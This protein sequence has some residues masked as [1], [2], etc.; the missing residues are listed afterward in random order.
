MQGDSLGTAPWPPWHG[1]AK[2]P[3]SPCAFLCFLSAW[4]AQ[5]VGGCPL[6]GT[7][8]REGRLAAPRS[9]LS[10]QGARGAAAVPRLPCAGGTR[11][12]PCHAPHGL[13]R[14]SWLGDSAQGAAFSQTNVA[15]V[16]EGTGRVRLH[17]PELLLPCLARSRHRGCR[18]SFCDSRRL[19]GL[20]ETP[21]GRAGVGRQG[22]QAGVGTHGHRCQQS[23][24]GRS[25]R[26]A[27]CARRRAR[28]GAGTAQPVLPSCGAAQG[29]EPALPGMC[30][31]GFFFGGDGG[32][33]FVDR[34]A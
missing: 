20:A 23:R 11:S 24:A 10:A 3:S 30:L 22:G 25:T 19:P 21:A 12:I 16:G 7:E 17:S 31:A 5:E 32:A 33:A 28:R 27:A 2:V 15:A 9:C 29:W 14:A 6:P 1:H 26:R 13:G 8:P 18:E 34:W 4:W